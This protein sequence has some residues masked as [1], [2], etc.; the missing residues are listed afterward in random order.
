LSEYEQARRE[1]E[2]QQQ[3]L[4]QLQTEYA[5][6]QQLEQLQQE[7]LAAQ[8]DE[9]NR[10]LHA[11]DQGREE[12]SYSSPQGSQEQQVQNDNDSAGISPQDDIGG[13]MA[14]L[15]DVGESREEAEALLDYLT[16]QYTTLMVQRRQVRLHLD[17]STTLWRNI[18]KS[19]FCVST[20]LL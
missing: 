19:S 13:G 6:L 15:H 5:Q 20:I 17:A 3:L 2:A 18:P 10:A 16:Q 12:Q 8:E 9:D 14:D 7:Q 11:H 4:Q 1:M